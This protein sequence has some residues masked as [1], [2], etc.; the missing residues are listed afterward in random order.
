[1]SPLS[2]KSYDD[3]QPVAW[4]GEMQPF[5]DHPSTHGRLTGLR[6]KPGKSRLIEIWSH[7]YNTYEPVLQYLEENKI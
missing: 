3:S 5:K 2:S 1:M 7:I 6:N 4:S